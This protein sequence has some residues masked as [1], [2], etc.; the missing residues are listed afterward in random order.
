MGRPGHPQSETLPMVSPPWAATP[1]GLHVP[2]GGPACRGT[3]THHLTGGVWWHPMARVLKE[4]NNKELEPKTS[5][6]Y[7]GIV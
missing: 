4:E 3:S 2:P 7:S 5:Q 6:R 1:D